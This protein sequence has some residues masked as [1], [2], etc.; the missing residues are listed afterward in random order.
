[1]NTERRRPQPEQL[2][3]RIVHEDDC[4]LALDK[5]PGIVVHPTYK[6]SAG[7]LLNGVLWHVRHRAD[8]S[9]GILTRLDK[10]TSGLVVIGITAGSHARMQKDAMHG[11]V[12]KTYLAIVEQRPSPASGR[13]VLPLGRDNADRRVVVVRDDGQPCETRY[14]TLAVLEDGK[15]VLAC[16]PITGRTHQIRV[17]L[18]ASGWPIVGDRAYGTAAREG[19]ESAPPGIGRQALHAWKMALPHPVTRQRLELT[20]PVPE[21]MRAIWGGS[22]DPPLHSMA[23]TRDGGGDETV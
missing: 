13:I 18:A 12:S 22:E 1:M 4:V 10:D 15:A 23:A 19:T 8:A 16:E 21:D 11:E 2:D 3:L 20:C 7:T 14:G 6:N 5:P 17:H 9:P